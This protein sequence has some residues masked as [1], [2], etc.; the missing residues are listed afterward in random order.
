[1]KRVVAI[2]TKKEIESFIDF[3]HDLYKND[4]HYVP[5][6]FIAQRDLITP[7]K[8][9][10]HDHSKVQ[11]FLAYDKDKV[12][13]RIAAILNNNHNS[14]NNAKDGFFGFYDCINDEEVSD[15]LFK[16][17]EE[18]LKSQGALTIIG[19]TNFSTNET[20]GLLVEGYDSPPFAMMVYN[21]PYYQTLIEKK[22]FNKKVDLMAYRFGDNGYDDKS[23]KV[24]EVLLRRLQGKG[25]TIRPLDKKRF[26]EE[27]EKVREVYNAAWDKN[28]GF[29]PMSEK[30][31]D[32]LA[33]DLK[34]ILDTD[35]CLVAEKEGKA[36]AFALAIPDINQVLINVKR[37]RL[38]PFGILKLLLGL[39]KING[40]RIIALGV[41]EGYRKL[42]IEACFY[43]NIIEAYRK[44][45]YKQ[46][47]A[48]WILEH[49]EL[50][51]RAIQNINGLP[52]KRY[53]IF[54]KA[55]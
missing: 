19:P 44:K 9:P 24:K 53:R 35:F 21:K 52:Y 15:K 7:G 10:F 43:G 37:G 41:M 16:S 55:L 49:N 4:P 42:G 47:E 30:E 20:C 32:Y 48:S 34:L 11:L 46:A 5:E 33:K 2:S 23:V 14:F 38:F 50:M 31:F 51:N 28:L 26:K 12:V 45:K 25:I 1:M 13:G 6:L 39:K 40:L 22:G 29:V 17:A 3:P 27:V 8:H 54:E 18:W 36:I